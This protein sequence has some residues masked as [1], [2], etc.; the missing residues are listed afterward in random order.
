MDLGLG[1][2]ASILGGL[3]GS[4]DVGELVADAV[5][6]D[7][8]VEGLTLASEDGGVNGVEGELVSPASRTA[9]NEVDGRD[10][11]AEIETG[12]AA[13]LT[14]VTTT[15]VVVSIVI[16]VVVIVIAVVTAGDRGSSGSR[17]SDDDG[18]QGPGGTAVDGAAA[19]VVVVVVVAIVVVV[20]VATV[21]VV[22]VVVVVTTSGGS[23]SRTIRSLGGEVAEAVGSHDIGNAQAVGVKGV[24]ERLSRVG[25]LN[26]GAANSGVNKRNNATKGLGG[27][28]SS[29][30]ADAG[31][32]HRKGVEVLLSGDKSLGSIDN[33]R[34]VAESSDNLV[35]KLKLG[36]RIGTSKQDTRSLAS[37]GGSLSGVA[38]GSEALDN[39]LNSTLLTEAS[40]G[41]SHEGSEKGSLGIHGDGKQRIECDRVKS[42][43]DETRIEDRP[44]GFKE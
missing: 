34:V 29:I 3:V 23:A 12:N 31:D 11:G 44:S 41:G 32:G 7:V 17:G 27:G 24:L 8:G 35:R 43:K 9:S 22:V 1:S 38:K 30:R 26:V 10:A 15:V 16:V 28:E 20:V 37:E 13:L 42:R 25:V 21:I 14:G 6:D 4:A 2:L 5:G 33:G 40:L 18:S 39:V 36:A 19:V